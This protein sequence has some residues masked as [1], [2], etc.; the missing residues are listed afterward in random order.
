MGRRARAALDRDS[1]ATRSLTARRLFSGSTQALADLAQFVE[2]NDRANRGLLAHADRQHREAAEEA[3]RERAREAEILEAQNARLR[4]S[5][6]SEAD[7]VASLRSLLRESERAVAS[8]AQRN[9]EKDQVRKSPLPLQRDPRIGIA[10]RA[11]DSF[12]RSVIVARLH[13]RRWRTR[14]PARR[15]RPTRETRTRRSSANRKRARTACATS[16]RGS[17]RGSAR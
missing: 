15:R 2:D 11:A 9:A 6:A 8:L 16:S 17:W 10:F 7:R 13:P 1:F 12:R 3:R 14:S 4:E 5:L